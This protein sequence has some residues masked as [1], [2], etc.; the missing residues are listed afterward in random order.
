MKAFAIK[1]E[2]L[3]DVV[4]IGLVEA[5]LDLPLEFRDVKSHR[6]LGP[7][8]TTVRGDL[9][10]SLAGRTRSS[11]ARVGDI[12]LDLDPIWLA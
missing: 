5:T 4:R 3:I 8:Q 2:K 6:E 7:E 12:E 9:G 10:G 11:A 1:V